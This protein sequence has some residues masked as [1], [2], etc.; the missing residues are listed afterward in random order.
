MI[1]NWVIFARVIWIIVNYIVNFYMMA[2]N[3]N[4]Q[5]LPH[6]SV[7]FTEN[8]KIIS[9]RF[10]D[11]PQKPLDRA[12]WWIEYILRNPKPAHLQSP[13]MALGWFAS[14]SYDV[15]LVA[16]GILVLIFALIFA[17]CYKCFTAINLRLKFSGTKKTN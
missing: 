5:H 10:R 13:T 17:A 4:T 16:L 1:T 15:L 11:Q 2:I 12:V 8:A 7:R 3:R 6:Y 9:N 14:N